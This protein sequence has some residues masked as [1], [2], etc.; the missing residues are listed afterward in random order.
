MMRDS[1]TAIFWVV[2]GGV[3]SIWSATYPFGD[4]NA[5]GPA[6]LPLAT[7]LILIVLGIFLFIHD[8]GRKQEG[9]P[10]TSKPLLP[11]GKTLLRVVISLGIIVLSAL[12]FK[13]LG[14]VLTVF[15]MLLFLKETIQAEKVKAALFYALVSTLGGVIV[16]QVLLKIRFPKGPFSF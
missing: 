14:F 5:P 1:V 16:F 13:I 7:G 3:I 9:P 11:R 10:G 6:F 2:V 4:W 12:L 8:R 15:L